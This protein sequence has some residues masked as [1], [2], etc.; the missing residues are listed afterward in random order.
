MET[1]KQIARALALVPMS[2]AAVVLF[3]LMVMT[4]AD[5]VLRSAF[6][7]PLG[8]APE[9]TRMAVAIIVFSALP[10][11]SAQGTHISVDLLD[12]LFRRLGILR[13]WEGLMSIACGVMLW[14]PAS[15]V[16]DLAARGAKR[17]TVTEFL[18]IPTFY[19]SYFI[20]AMVYV[21]MIALIVRGLLVLFVPRIVERIE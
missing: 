12:G 3:G 14:W 1:V 19:L 9:L 20:A 16:V 17:G 2:M 6:S 11:V 4:F 13:V 18:E 5:V 7:A 8:A 21:T 15:R 10:V